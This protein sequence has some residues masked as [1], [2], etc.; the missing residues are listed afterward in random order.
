MNLDD[1]VNRPGSLQGDVVLVTGGGAGLGAGPS[2]LDAAD[3]GA[4]VVVA[5]PGENGAE[6]ARLVLE[7]GGE[8]LWTRTDVTR[9][10]DVQAA[11]DLAVGRF[12][13]LDAV[14]H[15]ATSRHSSEVGTVEGLTDPTW[16]DHVAVSLRGAFL[17]AR[18]ALPHLS[19]GVGRFV[20]MT[21]PAGIEGS[22]TLPA[23]AAVKGALRGMARSLAVEWG[24]LGVT[25]VAVS[26]LAVTP[27][28][29]NAYRENPELEPR[30]RRLVPVG[31]VGDPEVDIA[32]VV[33]FLIGAGAG[34]V[35]GQT[36]GVD[37][38]R[39]TVS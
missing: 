19:R 38:G 10:E 26:P 2:C 31:R 14:V 7:R 22:A 25:V 27:A 15:N 39:L 18:A 36:L 29:A 9:A 30:L 23:Y 37:G 12:G 3:N 16:D 8:A 11:V 5:A 20:V 35:T 33:S 6:T 17:C 13:G 21:S 32:P 24:P 34:Y 1:T 28:L 4:R